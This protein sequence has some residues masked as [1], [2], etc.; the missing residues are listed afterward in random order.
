MVKLMDLIWEKVQNGDWLLIKTQVSSSSYSSWSRGQRKRASS[1]PNFTAPSGG[2]P[3]TCTHLLGL[4]H[5]LHSRHPAAALRWN[6]ASQGW[7]TSKRKTE[8]TAFIPPSVCFPDCALVQDWN[9]DG[10]TDGRME[11]GR[12]GIDCGWRHH[13][14]S[15]KLPK[16]RFILISFSF[17]FAFT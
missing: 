4:L 14:F 10:W 6:I 13:S 1:N 11:G 5:Q 2:A 8:K 7:K 15:G 3:T 12:L 9:R 16:F 17:G